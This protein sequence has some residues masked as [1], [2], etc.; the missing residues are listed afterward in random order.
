MVRPGHCRNCGIPSLD[1]LCNSFREYLRCTRCYR[2]L[3]DHLFLG[4]S[5]ECHA[6]QNWDSNNLGWYCLDR[7]IDDRTW[8]GTVHDID[9]SDIIRQYQNYIII[10]FGTARSENETIKYYFEME[11]EF[12]RT[13]PEETS[14][15]TTYMCNSFLILLNPFGYWPCRINPINSF[16]NFQFFPEKWSGFSKTKTCL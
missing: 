5:N 13:G 14:T 8:H 7:V 15:R 12:Y 1:V 16:V 2:H 9:V 4:D 10:T 11:V 3:P 6:C